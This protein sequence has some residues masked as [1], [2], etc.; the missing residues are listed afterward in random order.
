MLAYFQSIP[1]LARG[2][3]NIVMLKVESPGK[4]LEDL[5]QHIKKFNKLE[6]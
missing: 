5:L 2:L 1:R 6:N 3:D 4:H